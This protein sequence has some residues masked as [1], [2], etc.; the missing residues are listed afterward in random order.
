LQVLDFFDTEFL[1]TNSLVQ[2]RAIV[3]AGRALGIL[4]GIVLLASTGLAQEAP[5]VPEVVSQWNWPGILQRSLDAYALTGLL[6]PGDP[7][8]LNFAVCDTPTGVN[9]REG[10][11][12]LELTVSDSG[13]GG[14][15]LDHAQGRMEIPGSAG[16]AP[17]EGASSADQSKPGFRAKRW[18]G[19]MFLF[20][21]ILNGVRVA[22]QPWSR[23]ELKGPFFRDW[24]R[25]VGSYFSNVHVMDGDPLLTNFGSHAEEGAVYFRLFQQNTAGGSPEFDPRSR[26][27]WNSVLKGMGGAAAG[28]FF[29]EWGPVSECSL[30]NVGLRYQ[31]KAGWIDLIYT[32]VGGTALAVGEDILDRFLKKHFEPGRNRYLVA[33]VRVGGNPLRAMANLMAFRKPWYRDR[34]RAR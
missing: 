34:D 20:T 33:F 22:Y 14:L 9:C 27:Y 16:Q 32:P 28:S 18:F 30:G 3:G 29:F 2:P 17:S 31:K 26:A 13:S 10:E 19:Q 12:P 7:V 15:A 21:S 6:R 1:V 23:V 5:S 25:S 8:S 24:F 11:K 4:A